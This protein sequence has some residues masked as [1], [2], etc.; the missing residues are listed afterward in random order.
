MPVKD[1]YSTDNQ[2]IVI[3]GAGR[4]GRSFIGQLFSRAG[5]EVV[6]LDINNNLVKEINR[7]GKYEVVHRSN[8]GDEVITITNVRGISMNDRQHAVNELA[9]ADIAAISVGQHGFPDTI[10]VIADALILRRKLLGDEPL[11]FIIAENMRNADQYMRNELCKLLPGDYPPDKLVGLVET[12]IGKMVPIISHKALEE[13]PLRVYAE[14]YNTLI[15]S[16]RGFKNP[17]PEMPDLEPKENIKAWVDCKIFIHNLGHAAA[18][19]LGFRKLPDAVFIHEVLEDPEIFESTRMTMLQSADILLT[20]YPGEFDKPFLEAHIDDLLRRFRNVPLGDTVFRVGCDLYRKLSPDDRM[21]APIRAAIAL[22][23]PYSLILNALL[24]AISFRAK[25]ENGEY[26]PADLNFFS[27]AQL[28]QS[29]IL[30]NI[31]RLDFLI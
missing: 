27:E 22:N 25:D 6:F 31:C 14:P 28:G 15:L 18:A 29:H 23:M 13:L 11:D 16:A 2:K 17:I 21:A 9:V 30:R 24:A 3:F 7:Q 19:Y 4:I 10:P 1:K 5:F 8:E 26:F 12:S 20:L